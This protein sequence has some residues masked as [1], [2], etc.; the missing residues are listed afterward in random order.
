MPDAP[1]LHF[2][3]YRVGQRFRSAGITVTDA[4]IADF[5]AYDP[6]V[7]HRPQ[8][9]PQ[10]AFG[11]V[12]ASGWQT[13]A[14]TMR[15]MVDSGV[16][17]PDGGVGVTAERLHWSRPVHPGDTL[18]ILAEVESLRAFPRRRNGF[19]R[20]RVRTRNQFDQEV[21]SMTTM[22]MVQFRPEPA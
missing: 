21:L 13:A 19:V 14:Y 9:A 12:I 8:T 1:P 3:D 10:T 5:L 11:R 18:H 17:P 4:A 22:A 15:L 6:Q 7:F 2:E 20:L 16:L